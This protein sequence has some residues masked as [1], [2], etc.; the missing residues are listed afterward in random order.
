MKFLIAVFLPVSPFIPTS[1]FINFGDFCQP[2][3]LFHPPR[4]IFWPKFASLPV[5]SVLP[6]Y[7]KLESITLVDI[8]QNWLNWFHFAFLEGG[9]LVILIDSMIFLSPFLDVTKM[10]TSAVSFLTQLDSGILCL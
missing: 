3:R 7:L 2:P 6:F 4:L 10:S 1:L 8:L 5:Y 9:L